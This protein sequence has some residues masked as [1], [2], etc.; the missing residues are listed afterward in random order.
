MVREREEE[1]KR[2]RPPEKRRERMYSEQNGAEWRSIVEIKCLGNR[3]RNNI[4]DIRLFRDTFVLGI[5]SCFVISNCAPL[6][7]R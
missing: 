3:G 1:R 2:T 5:I 7:A 6:I 4:Y